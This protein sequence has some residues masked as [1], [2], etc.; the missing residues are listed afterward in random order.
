MTDIS[1]L[2]NEMMK[3]IFYFQSDKIPKG[4]VRPGEHFVYKVQGGYRVGLNV[5]PAWITVGGLYSTIRGALKCARK[6]A[7]L[8]NPFNKKDQSK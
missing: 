2:T 4:F 7:E 8:M 1:K 6:D 5:G 3:S